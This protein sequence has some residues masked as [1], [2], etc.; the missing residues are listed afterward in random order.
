MPP[1]PRISSSARIARAQSTTSDAPYTPTPAPPTTL[2]RP[3]GLSTRAVRA[4]TSAP[5][6]PA[7]TPP[8]SAPSNLPSHYLLPPTLPSPYTPTLEASLDAI[9]SFS[10]LSTSL[11]PIST[12]LRL[13]PSRSTNWPSLLHTLLAL[14]SG[15]L[16]LEEVLFLATRTL[17]PNQ[18]AENRR[19]LTTLY[20]T[21]KHL[22][23]RLTLRYD[24]LRAWHCDASG[25]SVAVASVPAPPFGVVQQAELT[26][27][28]GRRALQKNVWATLVAAP[29]KGYSTQAVRERMKHHVTDLD[30]YL[31]LSD[32]E[33]GTWADAALLG[34]TAQI[35]VQWEWVRG[36][37]AVLEKM[38]VF[39]YEELEGRADECEWFVDEVKKVKKGY[40]MVENKEE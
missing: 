34:M 38:E 27:I 2:T 32:E 30:G 26:A 35:L 36:N 6:T 7:P 33:V 3:H 4:L 21:R 14:S 8:A 11:Q 39:G 25:H 31:L 19:L 12:A 17:L 16:L 1:K 10:F 28:G 24:M 37:N 9:S 20:E 15:R 18:I 13:P 40:V 29:E 22:A 23:T 5:S